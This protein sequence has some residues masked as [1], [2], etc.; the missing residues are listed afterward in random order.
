M[1]LSIFTLVKAWA[2]LLCVLIQSSVRNQPNSK[3]NSYIIQI[4]IK[5]KQQQLFL[6]NK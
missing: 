4:K 1:R 5:K 2:R 3:V 6:Q